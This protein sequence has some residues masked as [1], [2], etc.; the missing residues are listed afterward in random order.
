MNTYVKAI[1]QEAARLYE[2]HMRKCGYGY[3]W[4]TLKCAMAKQYW[5]DLA[6]RSL[7]ATGD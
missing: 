5:L 6:E 3:L 2:D 4:A 1:E 7:V